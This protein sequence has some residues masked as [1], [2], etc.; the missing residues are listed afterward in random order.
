M[1]KMPARKLKDS[2]YQLRKSAVD[3]AVFIVLV[4]LYSFALVAIRVS[5]KYKKPR[6]ASLRFY[7]WVK[8]LVIKDDSGVSRLYLLEIAFKNMATKKTRTI[9]TIGG[10]AVGISFIVFLVSVGYGLQ[11]MVISRVARLDELKQAEVLPGLSKDLSLNDE[12]LAKFKEIPNVTNVLPLIAVVGRI[13]YENSVSDIAVYGATADYLKFSALQPV[14][15]TLFESNSVSLEMPSRGEVAGASTEVGVKGSEIGVVSYQIDPESWLKVRNAP[16]TNGKILGY[17]KRV[18]GQT[19]GTE[20]WGDSYGTEADNVTLGKWVKGKFLLWKKTLCDTISNSECVD[21]QYVV[22]RNEDQSQTQTDGYAAEISMK[23][24]ANEPVS[25]VLGVTSDLP[26]IEIASESAAATSQSLEKV[27]IKSAE[28]RQIVVNRSVLQLLNISEN[29]AVG[30]NVTLSM[31]VVGDLLDDSSKRVES[32]PVTYTI[33]GVIPDE[34]TPIVYVPFMDV[35]SL[36]VNRYSQA[37]VIVKDKSNLAVARVMIE[38]EGYGTVSVADTVAQID[39]L[40]L[41]FRLLLSV[42]GMVALFVAALGMFNTLTVSLLERTREVGLMKAMGMKSGEVKSLFLTESMI[43]GLYGGIFG[44][45]LGVVA[46]KALSV[47]LSMLSLVKGVGF[48]D[49][50]YVPPA[51]VL[52]VLVLSVA[53]GVLTGYFPARRATRISALNALRYE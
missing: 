21:G 42:L 46:G 10:M 22:L 34:G 1:K 49:V 5:R 14:K 11:Q 33:V 35:R 40:F 26:V 18:E 37:K 29:D 3:T 52:A 28:K 4:I 41:N 30:K 12:V 32:F 15:G 6:E 16:G 19:S 27:E 47:I 39:S 25:K 2:L 7:Q 51:F 20:V 17:T 44:L 38:S 8:S 45:I 43:M 31:V 23:V 48:I 36:G 53:V 13:S 50:S 9:V 24:L